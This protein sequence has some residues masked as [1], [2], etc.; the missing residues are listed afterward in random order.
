MV[1]DSSSSELTLTIM[2]FA[3]VIFFPIIL[4]YT[5]WVYR[6]LRG[7]INEKVLQDNQESSY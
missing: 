7:P 2:L 1:W 4:T 3:T 5:A 6:V